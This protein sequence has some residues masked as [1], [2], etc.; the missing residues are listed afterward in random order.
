MSVF[1]PLSTR[2]MLIR[3][4]VVYMGIIAS[5]FGVANLVGPVLGGALTEHVSW[6]WCRS[7]PWLS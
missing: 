5:M 7:N 3:H 2:H 1:L 4:S 6:R